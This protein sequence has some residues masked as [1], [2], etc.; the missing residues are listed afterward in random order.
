VFGGFTFEPSDTAGEDLASAGY[1]KGVAMGGDLSR[2]PNGQ[3]PKLMISARRDPLG[4]NLDRLQVVKGWLAADGSTREHIYNVAWSGARRLDDDG[5][6][7]AVGSTVDL[8]TASYGN[9]IGSPQL[10][11]VWTDPDFNPAE[12]AFYY[13]RV[14]EIPTPRHQ[15]YDALAL[16]IDPDTTGYATTIQERA[17]STP[18]WYTP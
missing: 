10:V 17:W 9:T 6:L 16:G 14:L 3:A 11:T 4:A 15:V 7:P 12:P 2:A 5:G 13:V 1:A 8:A 18:I